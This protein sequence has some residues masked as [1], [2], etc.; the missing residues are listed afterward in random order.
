MVWSFDKNYIFIHIP[1]TAGTS[2]EGYLGKHKIN[3]NHGYGVFN[4][5]VF[6]HFTYNEIKNYLISNGKK[7][8]F[9]QSIK[10]TVVRHPI[11]RLISE[12][13]WTPLKIGMISGKLFE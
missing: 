9:N 1:K 4:G 5:K 3:K 13:K 11:D 2:I 10:F 12:Y 6:Q 8:F 7:E